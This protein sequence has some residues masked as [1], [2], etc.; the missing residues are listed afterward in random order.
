MGPLFPRGG[1]PPPP[2]LLSMFALRNGSGLT[3]HWDGSSCKK[4]YMPSPLFWLPGSGA[5]S[6]V[7]IAVSAGW[8]RVG[9]GLLTG[10]GAGFQFLEGTD[11]T[12]SA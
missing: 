6:Q 11:G 1:A 9:L 5:S 2:L 8:E 12:S 10:R 7:V 4:S 3:P